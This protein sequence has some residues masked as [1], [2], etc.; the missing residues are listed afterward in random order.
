MSDTNFDTVSNQTLA[1]AQ[2]DALL[3]SRVASAGNRPDDFIEEI[4]LFFCFFLSQVCIMKISV[5]FNE[6]GS[7]SI[8]TY[9]F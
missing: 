9:L 3:Q 5:I 6:E 1:W 7:H 2:S 4:C 8:D